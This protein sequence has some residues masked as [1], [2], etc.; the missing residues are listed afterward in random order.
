MKKIFTILMTLTLFI[1]AFAGCAKQDSVVIDNKKEETNGRY[2][3]TVADL[4]GGTNDQFK[5]MFN[6]EC[7]AKISGMGGAMLTDHATGINV[8]Y[9]FYS[10][11]VWNTDILPNVIY[12]ENPFVDDVKIYRISLYADYDGTAITD[13]SVLKLVFETDGTVDSKVINKLLEQSPPLEKY[14]YPLYVSEANIK[15]THDIY[16]AEYAAMGMKFVVT[17]F[18]IDGQMVAHNVLMEKPELL[19]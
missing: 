1:T 6:G 3:S 18:D 5:E 13:Q 2:V 11:N 9:Q 16:T 12:S 17:Y 15:V 8:L 7:T 14:E 10:G 19:Q 4:V